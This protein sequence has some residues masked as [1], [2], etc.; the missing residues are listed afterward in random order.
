MSTPASHNGSVGELTPRSKIK[1]MLAALDNNSDDNVSPRLNVSRPKKT[2]SGANESNKIPVSI[3]NIAESEVGDEDDSD[4]V[5]PRGKLASGLYSNRR[6]APQSETSDTSPAS[7]AYTTIKEQSLQKSPTPTGT[8]VLEEQLGYSFP[9]A[10]PVGWTKKVLRRKKQKVIEPED[11]DSASENQS[12]GLDASRQVHDSKSPQS[13]GLSEGG[14]STRSRSGMPKLRMEHGSHTESDDSESGLPDNPL[15]DPIFLEQVAQKRREREVKDAE[16]EKKR[17]EKQKRLGSSRKSKRDRFTS[18][19]S[20]VE[21]EE[22][23]VAMGRKLTQQSRPTR[24]ASKKALEEMSR[25][26]QRLSRNMQ[27]AHEA[28]TKKKI[29]KD[30]LLERFR[31]RKIAAVPAPERPSSSAGISSVPVSDFEGTDKRQTPPTSPENLGKSLDPQKMYTMG[32]PVATVVFDA[33]EELPSSE[34]VL[35]SQPVDKGKGRAI[36]ERTA[37]EI[38]EFKRSKGPSFTQPPIKIR[39][40]R[41]PIRP[42]GFALDSDSDLEVLPTKNTISKKSDVFDRLPTTKAAKNPSLIKLRALAHL[43]SPSNQKKNAKSSMTSSELQMSLRRQ[44]RQQAAKERADKIQELRDRGVVIQTTEERQHDQMMVEDMLEK[45]RRE[46]EELTKKEKEAAKKEKRDNGEDSGLDSSGDEDYQERDDEA[47]VELSGSDEEAREDDEENDDDDDDGD[48]SASHGDQDKLMPLIDNEAS[49][50]SD[51]VEADQVDEII[52]GDSTLMNQDSEEELNITHTNRRGKLNRV[53]A[54]DSDDFDEDEEKVALAQGSAPSSTKPIVNPFEGKTSSSG[55]PS[56]GLTQA[57]ASTMTGSR[58]CGTQAGEEEDPLAVLSSMPMPD[59]PIL[60]E[61]SIIRDSQIQADDEQDIDLH[62]T[63]SQ[64]DQDTAPMERTWMATQFS[65]M[66]DP[67]QDAGFQKSSPIASRFMPA[68]PST[69]D[70]VIL[71]PDVI[72]ESPA[73]KKKG[74]LQRRT[75]AITTFSDTEDEDLARTI[76]DDDEFEVSANAFDVMKRAIKKPEKLAES[77]DKKRSNAKGM[78]EEQA[79][80]SEDEYAGLGG[81]SDDDSEAEEDEEVRKMIDEGHVDVDE[82]K[83]AAFYASVLSDSRNV[84]QS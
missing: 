5:A 4:V 29:S 84:F 69:I 49:E 34:E 30:S 10:K 8:S 68:P 52:D 64:I 21:S 26:T 27:L 47:D 16:E 41:Y 46:G 39:P 54:D 7:D 12:R 28:K 42:E 79:E 20:G 83:I 61:E 32:E 36:P 22:E 76:N 25:E 74:R 73:I 75:E 48:E 65:Q 13:P 17:A 44:A 58:D 19:M 2:V 38:A 33:D 81:A 56:M 18:E 43:T 67:T 66:P 72:Y 62:F 57:F 24:K 55:I 9:Q 51:E 45:A 77:F 59:F 35:V 14:S 23:D 70:T 50:D 53:L 3:P 6:T 82:R 40:P 71:A 11:S 31:F 78:V 60:E 1:A 37:E 80:E 15:K 63:Q